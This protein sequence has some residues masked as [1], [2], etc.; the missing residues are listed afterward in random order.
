VVTLADIRV[1]PA[2]A[3]AIPSAA[4][5]EAAQVDVTL[6]RIEASQPDRYDRLQRLLLT[7]EVS[8]RHAVSQACAA[9]RRLARQQGAAATLTQALGTQLCAT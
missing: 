8:A 5:T 1:Q 2:A 6:E 7:C 3:G 4:A 9:V